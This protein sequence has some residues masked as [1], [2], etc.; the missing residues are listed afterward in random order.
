MRYAI[1]GGLLMLLDT[2]VEQKLL[3]ITNLLI[4]CEIKYSISYPKEHSVVQGS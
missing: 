3:Q 4:L 1:M 2:I